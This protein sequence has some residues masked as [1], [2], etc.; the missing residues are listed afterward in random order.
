MIICMGWRRYH[1]R[2]PLFTKPWSKKHKLTTY[3]LSPLGWI[4][5]ILL[6]S[7]L[8]TAGGAIY[9][10]ACALCAFKGY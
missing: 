7:L 6:F 9:F 10:S 8:G 1:Y 5:L 4:V 3:L 2:R